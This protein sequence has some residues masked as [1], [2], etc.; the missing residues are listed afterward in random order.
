M[1]S[2]VS[3]EELAKIAGVKATTVRRVAFELL[4]LLELDLESHGV[5]VKN[6][7]T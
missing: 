6:G 1:K 4:E 7:A 3:A 2:G 5:A